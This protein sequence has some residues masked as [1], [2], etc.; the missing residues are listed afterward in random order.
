MAHETPTITA[1]P[2]PQTGTRF[3]QR[4]RK[5]GRLPAVIYG[6]KSDPVTISV[7]EKE[8]LNHLHQ[9]MHVIEVNIEGGK[10]ET[11][12]VKDL[13]FGFMGDNVIH[14]DFARVDLDEE[15]H[16]SVLMI[17]TGKAPEALKP[18]AIVS[19][20]ITQLPVICKVR[21]IPDEIKVNTAITEGTVLTAG[22]VELPADIRLDLAP[23]T[24]IMTISFIHAEEAEGEEVEVGDVSAEPEVIDDVKE[25]DSEKKADK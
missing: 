10:A 18:D 20:P 4:L 7:D 11:C 19:H 22:E 3:A 14:L 1:L 9:G 12:L 8:I 2:R 16:V 15:V 23:E 17:F 5:T 25:D 6:H 21:S 24:P 13:Q